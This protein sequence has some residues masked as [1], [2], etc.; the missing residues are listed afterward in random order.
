MFL[1]KEQQQQQQKSAKEW[2]ETEVCYPPSKDL[3]YDCK[4]SHSVGEKNKITQWDL[5]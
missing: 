3:K 1:K 5:R 4:D 2:K